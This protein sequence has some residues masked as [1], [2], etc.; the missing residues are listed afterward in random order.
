MNNHIDIEISD[1]LVSEE[2]KSKQDYL[3]A[4][5]DHVINSLVD[6]S[7][8]RRKR[9]FKMR[10]MRGGVRDPEEFEYLTSNF[11]IGNS[12]ELRFT[13]IIRN[14]IDALIGIL[15]TADFDFKVSVGD[16]DT[17][18]ASDVMRSMDMVK[19]I[20]RQLE[21]KIGNV[22]VTDQ[23][24]TIIKNSKELINSGWKS[25]F[26]KS[27]ND[28]IKY[29]KN[30]VDTN[31][32]DIR[33][34]LMED[35]AVTGECL[36]RVVCDQYGKMAKPEALLPEN[37]YTETRRD[38]KNFKESSR[39][40]YVRYMT[41]EDAILKYGQFMTSQQKHDLASTHI[42][43]HTINSRDIRELGNISKDGKKILRDEFK[44]DNK[45][46]C[47]VYESEWIANNEKKIDPKHFKGNMTVDG[48]DKV[49]SVGYR[50][51]RY[52]SVRINEDMYF[53][54]G[55]SDFIKRSKKDPDK[56]CLSFNG[57]QFEHRNGEPY[58]LT[59][60][61]KDIQD[62]V[63][64]MYYHRDNLVAHSGV[65]GS[66]V[67]V[68][69]LPDFLGNDM[70]ERLMKVIALKKQ[71]IEPFNS[72]QNEGK[73]SNS[74]SSDF[75]GGVEGSLLSSIT[76]II[77]QLDEEAS[78]IT[79]VT[80]Q[81]MGLIEQRD[82]V[83]NVK[84]GISQASLV[85]K[86][87]YDQHDIVTKN[88]LTD[89]LGVTQCSME[90]EDDFYGTYLT[91]THFE[92]F[93]VIPKYFS[94]SD[95]NIHVVSSSN[96]FHKLN[97]AKHAAISLSNT[98]SIEIGL[99]MRIIKSDSLNEVIRIVD[100][101]SSGDQESQSMIGNLQNQLEQLTN[102]NKDLQKK[103][104]QVNK[105]EADLKKAKID[106][107]KELAIRKLDLT[108]RSRLDTREYNDDQLEIKKEA[109]KLERD[110]LYMSTNKN[111]QEIKNF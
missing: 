97:E 87:M 102:Q 33:K 8:E 31:I 41:V 101:M 10:D 51:D 72:A 81:M 109:L 9:M 75:K 74:V 24:D 96:E 43:K 79:G 4:M 58:S 32:N 88:M 94:F 73:Q 12:A 2:D 92:S 49:H 28:V 47:R 1:F 80:P 66:R 84:T 3:V 56:A 13:P 15:S 63:D 71:G 25:A 20:Y 11:G 46:Y 69:T 5:T 18:K 78:K 106:N 70:M 6:E 23:I 16:T 55:K 19:N 86:N 82:A 108:E 21:E 34:D 53:N 65:N 59:W 39:G 50:Q 60:K 77:N 61:C 17:I 89:L 85:L 57:I 45:R 90:D 29:Y 111:A 110:Q 7:I 91:D 22:T 38:Q 104:E 76:G 103:L 105:Y 54:M 67:D 40:V 68:S 52:Q 83:N 107:D 42:I 98:G 48:P 30:D 26:E 64:I 62:M 99:L 100:K 44:H 14:R 35:L 95:Y 36:Y 27:A 37:Y 93:R